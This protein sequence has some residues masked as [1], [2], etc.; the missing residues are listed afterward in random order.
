MVRLALVDSAIEFCEK[1]GAVRITSDPVPSQKGVSTYDIDLPMDIEFSR[2]LAVWVG[3]RKIYTA[4]DVTVSDV[5]GVFP[6]EVPDTGA[7]SYG[8]VIE[9]KALTLVPAPDQDDLPIIIRSTTRPS[10][11]AKTLDDNLFDQWAEVIIHG[12]LFRLCST[13]GQPFSDSLLA[14]QA[15]ARFY[16]AIGHAKIDANRGRV[17]GSIAVKPRPFA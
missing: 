10:R 4:P 3:S 6:Q 7:A 14:G 15:E 2:V 16:A 9:P 5:R 11:N 17:I 1:T 8:V 13:P 12:A